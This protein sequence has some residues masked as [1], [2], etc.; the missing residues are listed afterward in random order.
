MMNLQDFRNTTYKEGA[1]GP[2]EY[3]CWGLVRDA[4]IHLFGKEPLPMLGDVKP[5]Q[6]RSITLEAKNL[7]ALLGYSET[8][9]KPGAIALAYLGALCAHV[10]IVVEVDG[11]LKIL[12]TDAPTGAILTS[13]NAFSRKYTK[14]IYYDN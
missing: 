12:E 9:I 1:R 13:A 8:H 11:S 5:K 3:D 6:L 7:P 10:G 14:V 4:R 2:K